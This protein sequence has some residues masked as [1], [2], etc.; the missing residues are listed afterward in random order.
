MQESQEMTLALSGMPYLFF[1]SLSPGF[2]GRQ[3][4]AMIRTLGSTALHENTPYEDLH[5]MVSLVYLFI[6]GKGHTVG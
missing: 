6:G 5:E 2:P 3:R 4:P 1:G